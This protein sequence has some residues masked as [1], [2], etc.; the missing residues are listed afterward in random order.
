MQE[1]AKGIS[2][3]VE[4]TLR[5]PTVLSTMWSRKIFTTADRE[6]IKNL[7]TITNRQRFIE[8]LGT[9]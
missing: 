7:D 5:E 6:A 8:I 4:G 1:F 2:E 9:M 3:H